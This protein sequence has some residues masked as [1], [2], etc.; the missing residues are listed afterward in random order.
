MALKALGHAI[1]KA[2]TIAEILKRRVKDLHQLTEIS[3]VRIVDT[4][5]PIEEGLN[6]IE[7]QRQVSMITITLSVK[8]LDSSAPGY[9]APLPHSEVQPIEDKPDQGTFIFTP[10]AFPLK[11]CSHRSPHPLPQVATEGGV[12]EGAGVTADEAEGEAIRGGR[13][14]RLWLQARTPFEVGVEGAVVAARV[15]GASGVL[16]PRTERGINE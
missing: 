13:P 6:T 15:V 3:S 1:S 9:Q 12:A 14:P 4:W 7:T 8:P 2:V 10:I 11:P 5:E 16:T